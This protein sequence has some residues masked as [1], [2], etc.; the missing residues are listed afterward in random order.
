MDNPITVEADINAPIEKIWEFYN[1]PEH[2]TKWNSP[3]NDWHT[4]KAENDLKTG[5]K[6]LY[7][8]EAKDGSTGFDFGGTYTE[9]IENSL[10]KYTMDDGRKV[11]VE[12]SQENDNPTKVVVTFDPENENAPEFQKQGWQG[13]LD[14]F[15]KY[16]ESN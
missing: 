15:K 1:T 3:S 5:G 13:I 12:M 16:V 9:V 4:P 14:N 11:V 2:I 6:F 8:M 7:R 10:M